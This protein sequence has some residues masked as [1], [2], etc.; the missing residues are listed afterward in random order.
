MIDRKA[1]LDDLKQQVKAVE[2]DLARQVKALPEVSARLRSEYD[3]A[4]KLGR[5][6]ATWTSWLDE[7]VTQ[8]AVAW[9]LGTVFVRFCEDN[10]LIPEPYLTGP[11]ADRRELAESRYEAY[12]DSDEDP[13]YRGWLEKAF[14][15]LGQGQA[16]RLLFD[17]RHNPLYQVPLSHD[18]ARELVEFWRGR[19][20]SGVLVH[21]FTDPLNEDGTEGWDT[22]FLGDLYQDLSEAAR[23]TY[24]LLQTPE[25]VEEFIL[26]RTMNPAVREFGYEDLKMIDPTC[27]SGH[28]VLGA[29]RRLVRLWAAGQPGRDVHERVRAA[30]DSV[31]GVDIN[32][33]AVAIARFR[34]LVAAMAA[35]GVR[36][37]GETA[38]FEWPIH[39]AVG[40]S[41]IKARQL[42][43][44]LA[45]DGEEKVA[46][47]PLA[48]F[49][50]LTEDV[51]EEPQILEEGRY[52]LVVGNPPYVTVKDKKLNELYRELYSACSGTYALSV[53][54]AQRFFELAKRGG[55]DGFGYG[56]VGQITAS[57][58]MKREFGTRLIEEYF[59]RNVEL[60]EVIDT[61]GAYIPGHGTPTVILVGK[62]R[63]GRM[64]SATVRA[65]RGIQGEPSAPRI[66]REGLV[67]SAIVR[68]VD[69]PGTVSR[70]VAVEDLDRE[71]YFGKH[72]WVLSD[73]GIEVMGQMA[74]AGDRSLKSIIEPP[75]GRAIRA[76]AD[77]AYLRP[78]RRTYRT[79]TGPEGL[80]P[81]MVGEV[82]RDWDANPT[83]SIWYPYAPNIDTRSLEVDLWPL[84][85]VLEARRT[86]QGDMAAAGLRWWDYMQYTASAYRTPLSISFSFVATHNHFVLDRGGRVFN[87]S[88]P[89]IKLA[90]DATEKDYLRVVGIL[91]SSSACFWLK[92][93]SHNMGSTVDSKGARQ[94]T[95][96]F[97][98]FFQ[99]NG[100]PMAEFPVPAE[101]PSGL[102]AAIDTLAQR[103]TSV[104]PSVM[105]TERTPTSAE[106][107]ECRS[108]WESVRAQ[109]ITLQEELDWQVYSLYN[110]HS[111]DLRVSEDP[112]DPNIPELALGERAFEIVLA[113]RVAAGEASDEWFKRHGS[114]PITEIPAH[115]PA[116]YREIVQK[117]IDAIESN[118]AIG[119]VERPE[120]KRRWA[121]EGWDAL[122]EKA[123]RAWLLDRM[124]N[125]DL[126]FD[127]NGQPT[128]LTLARLTDALSRDEDFVS[129]AK[130]YAPRK[131]FAKVVAEL[132]TDEHVPFLPA[133]R[134]KPSGLK[135]RADWEEVW[136]L[137]RKEDAAPDE[138]AKRK[139][140]DSIPV[141]PKYTSADFLRPS[142]WR[143]RGKLDVPKER[144]ISYGQTNSATPELYGWAGWDHK[145]QAQALATY[146]TNT[147]LSTEEITPFLAGLLEL[148][149][150]LY[151]WHNEFDMLYS[152]SPADFFA[153]YRQQMQGEHGLTD[154]DLRGWRPLAATRGRRAAVKQ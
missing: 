91:N 84:R 111:E 99:F 68:Q 21:D 69:Q 76:G 72:P 71:H 67:W 77:E 119:M 115:W 31:H 48:S 58:F 149:P 112:D 63:A 8:V 126:W 41:L 147:A 135:K 89:V 54:F 134:Y 19:D 28:F 46:G 141:P 4:R 12:V 151:Q 81:L 16:G 79:V 42:E 3:Q 35:S 152:G 130:L 36:T 104:G 88:A 96:P 131:D 150:W 98:D 20:E 80:R 110:L 140:R 93:V 143:A 45:L 13:T 23:K 60:T 108:R 124:E 103:L 15:K 118:R 144:F 2:A 56:F 5:T 7:R 52:H 100:T 57:S 87:R 73:G 17:K 24:A 109:M 128:I 139:I 33:F 136:D 121:T 129:V 116:P 66:G 40:D 9:V 90:T 43:L 92:Q 32:P 153:G 62:R 26:D 142:Y 1:L 39:L 83:E 86:F 44:V 10:R 78:S 51:Q 146:F 148:Q 50:Y 133:L 101:L 123:L 27:G 22:R 97:E 125:R 75:I 70:W 114:T 85:R 65:V 11:D 38:K 132:I 30:L 14:E 47:D 117:R 34:L 102:A 74:K 122:Q 37:L 127:Q 137:Q 95:L 154:D 61:S 64:R 53:P 55:A 6:A 120:Y 113:R 105:L 94:S 59:A 82:V 106:L 18:G 138:P 107:R 29:F 145:E 25:F 49:A